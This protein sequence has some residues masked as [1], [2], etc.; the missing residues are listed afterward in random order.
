MPVPGRLTST[1]AA[2]AAPAT[3]AVT[4]SAAG[5]YRLRRKGRVRRLVPPRPVGADGLPPVVT[6]AADG[7]D[8][9]RPG[10]RPGGRRLRPGPGRGDRAPGR[11]DGT[12]G[13]ARRRAR[14]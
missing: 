2:T 11:A 14:R 1:L 8:V 10:R 3:T 7:S 9:S 5:T 6:V 4:A 12:P 13:R